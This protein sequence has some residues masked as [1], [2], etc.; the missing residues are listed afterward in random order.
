[1]NFNSN[2]SCAYPPPLAV[3]LPSFND[4]TRF[5]T[6]KQPDL[7]IDV[8]LVTVKHCEFLA[9]YNELKYP[10][11]YHFDG[12]G[13]VYFTDFGSSQQERV[14]VA[15]VLTRSEGST[16]RN[17]V[18]ICLK[19][20]ASILHPKVL[21]FVG[22]CSGLNPDITKLGDV[23]VSINLTTYA[24]K[25]KASDQEQW[26]G[27]HGFTGRQ[28]FHLTMNC[29]DG[30]ERPPLKSPEDHYISSVHC[31]DFLSGPEQIRT[32][33][34]RK[35]LVNRHPSVGGVDMEGEGECM[36]LKHSY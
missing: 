5:T 24:S 1:M 27:I 20:A 28:Y 15:L 19:N 36:S 6:M 32:E 3:D 14:K 13:C 8:L 9:C 35:E 29:G 30:W 25:V 12:L 23:I 33:C 4:V 7:P 2:K 18:S 17:S 10:F 26:V 11:G 31:K 22:T 34:W 16:D 21:I